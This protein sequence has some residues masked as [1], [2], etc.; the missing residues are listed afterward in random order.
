MICGVCTVGT[1]NNVYIRTLLCVSQYNIIG[2]Y[3]G[4]NFSLTV[5]SR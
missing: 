5:S 3:F 2:S 1:I 4:D